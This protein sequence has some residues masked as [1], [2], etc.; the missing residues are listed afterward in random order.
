MTG[1]QTCA[2]PILPAKAAVDADPDNG[3]DASPAVEAKV[4]WVSAEADATHVTTD[5]NGAAKF[6]GLKAGT[7]YLVETKAPTGYNLLNKPVEVT[8]TKGVESDTTHLLE[9][10]NAA[11]PVANYTGTVLPSTGGIGT[12]IFYVVGGLLVAGAGIVLITKKRMKKEQ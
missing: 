10:V 12:T 1:V 9:K 2:L 11:A 4:E 3:V 5:D 8:V 6:D 7:Y